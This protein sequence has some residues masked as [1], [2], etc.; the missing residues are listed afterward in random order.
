VDMCRGNLGRSPRGLP[1]ALRTESA[2]G[3]CGTTG[4]GD[5]AVNF[6][7]APRAVASVGQLDNEQL[8]SPGG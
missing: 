6:G 8:G 7:A 1:D 5:E 4:D 2:R 3:R